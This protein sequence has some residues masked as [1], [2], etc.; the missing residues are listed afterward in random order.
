MD[1]RV[2]LRDREVEMSPLFVR[3]SVCQIGIREK[4]RGIMA[5]DVEDRSR[6]PEIESYLGEKTR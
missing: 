1:R 2:L 6:T 5:A 4:S 3:A